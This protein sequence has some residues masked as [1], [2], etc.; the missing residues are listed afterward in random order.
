[1]KLYRY[2]SIDGD[3]LH[4]ALDLIV[5]KR[6]H[7]STWELMN[8]P[9]EGTWEP[10]EPGAYYNSPNWQRNASALR[11]ILSATRFT[12]FT[13]NCINPLLWAHYAGGFGGVAFEYEFDD[14]YDI[15]PIDY[16]GRKVIDPNEIDQVIKGNKLPQDIN[17]LL[18]KQKCW[19][20]EREFRLFGQG[21]DVFIKKSPTKVIFGIKCSESSKVL[22]DIVKKY[23][24]NVGYL[25][26]AQDDIYSVVDL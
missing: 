18:S 2:K 4:H 16:T 15:R 1:M 8:D 5:N 22:V 13:K 6:I 11:G 20:Y 21:N 25:T 14:S 3:G 17:L 12:C 24:L 9:G 19:K 10:S 7:L 26:L 23:N